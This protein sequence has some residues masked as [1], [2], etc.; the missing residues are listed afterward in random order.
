MHTLILNASPRPDGTIARMMGLAKEIAGDSAIFVDVCRLNIRPCT[1]CMACRKTGR[2]GLPRD[3]AHRIAEQLSRT[4][5]LIVGTPVYWANM[6]GQLKVLFD[7]LVPGFMEESARGFP[8]GRLRSRRAIVVT[9]CTTPFPFDRI[10]G[11]SSGAQRAVK[12]ILRTAG[13]SVRSI[14][15]AGTRG[16]SRCPARAV[17]RLERLIVRAGKRSRALS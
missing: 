9:A 17:S 13:M 4:D 1:A 16:G 2:C 14:R 12:E 11:Q 3:D 7:R 8:R 5:L 10:F 6:N 15:I